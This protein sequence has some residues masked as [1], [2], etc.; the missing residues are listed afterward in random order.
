[1]VRKQDVPLNEAPRLGLLRLCDLAWCLGDSD[2]GG[3][4]LVPI[5][6]MSKLRLGELVDMLVPSAASFPCYHSFHQASGPVNGSGV[7][8]LSTLSRDIVWLP[9]RL[10]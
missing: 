6:W 9:L 8:R 3:P 7:L 10:A 5:L 4:F 1:M 2:W